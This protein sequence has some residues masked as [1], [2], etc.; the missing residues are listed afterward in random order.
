[1]SSRTISP[2]NADRTV[3]RIK[4]FAKL[5]DEAIT[6]PGTNYRIGW[7][8]II[9]IIPGIGDFASAALSI[10]IVVQAQ[11]LGVSRRVLLKMI[12]NVGLDSL[13]GAVPL[14]GDFF[15]ATFKSNIRNVK[16]LEK[17]LASRQDPA[18]GRPKGDAQ[19]TD[20]RNAINI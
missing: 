19:R 3:E 16:L 8:A 12:A 7:D 4:T 17:S 1:M 15:D 11:R 2:P 20:N 6:I 18:V 5:L 10:Y 13:V 9:G 14:A